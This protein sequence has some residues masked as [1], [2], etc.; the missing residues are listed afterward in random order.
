[1]EQDL[2]I[3]AHYSHCRQRADFLRAESQCLVCFESKPG[4]DF[5][6]TCPECRLM[7]CKD[8]LRGYCESR[9]GEGTVQSI[10]CCTPKCPHELDSGL[11][12][13]LVGEEVR[14]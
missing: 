4:S 13:A 11:I 1:M 2:A 6:P 9:I 14:D 5:G 12:L 8:C 3:L 10:N 7:Y